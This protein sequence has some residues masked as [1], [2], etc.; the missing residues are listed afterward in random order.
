M[1]ETFQIRKA[2][3]EDAPGILQC[4]ERAFAPYR[5]SYTAAAFAETVL[6]KETLRR[7]FQE[8]TVLVGVGEE[9]HIIGTIAYNVDKNGNGRIRG[10]AVLPDWHGLG[11]ADRLLDQA[12]SDLRGL[13]CRVIGLETARPLQRAIRFYEKRGFR[14]T[15]E[16]ADFFGMELIP[17]RKEMGSRGNATGRN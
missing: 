9:S 10:M 2:R 1:T 4:L 11:V 17:H 13:G 15:G 12:E 5:E 16:A 8:M 14:A 3:R 7:R 6:N